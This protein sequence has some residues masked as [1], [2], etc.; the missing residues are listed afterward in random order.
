MQSF[1]LQK[2]EEVLLDG[3][4]SL[5]PTPA[6]TSAQ[7]FGVPATVDAKAYFITVPL[8]SWLD[9]RTSGTGLL[10]LQIPLLLQ[11]FP[12]AVCTYVCTV[13]AK[14]AGTFKAT[15]QGCQGV[16]HEHSQIHVGCHPMNG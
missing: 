11:Q 4:T 6:T 10:A 3:S 16:M 9:F 12:S 1:R 2:C 15:A 8:L 5:Y 13:L 7:V 14:P